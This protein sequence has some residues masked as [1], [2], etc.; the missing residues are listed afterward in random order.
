MDT[1]TFC[2]LVSTSGEMKRSSV[3]IVLN[4]TTSGAGDDGRISLGAPR[5]CLRNVSYDCGMN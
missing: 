3:D 1:D 4:L 5:A 2:E